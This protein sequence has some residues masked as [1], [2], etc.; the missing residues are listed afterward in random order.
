MSTVRT[1][2]LVLLAACGAA[3]AP[4]V[5][6]TC[7][8]DCNDRDGV[9]I[10]E[11][12]NVVNIFLG[13]MPMATCPNADRNGDGS[14]SIDEVVAAVN[15]FLGDPTSCP[16]VAP[17]TPE[18]T[19]TAT[20]PPDDTATPA[21]TVAPTAPLPSPT[22]TFTT[23][24]TRTLTPPPSATRSPTLTVTST[25]SAT[26]TSTF[27]PTATPAAS[28]TP[29]PAVC[30]NGFLEEGETCAKCAVD[31]KVKSCT[32]TTTVLTFDVTFAPPLGQNASS[33]TALVG[34]RSDTVGLPG[35]GTGSCVGGSKDGKACASGADCPG[36]QCVQPRSRVKNTP[37]GSIVGVND[38]DYAVR[39]VL[40]RSSQIAPGRIFSVDFLGCQGAAAPTAANFGCTVEGCASSFG[41]IDG[42]RCTV[43]AP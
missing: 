7:V 22:T 12:V 25:A 41:S 13:N 28:P 30:G 23:T 31:C 43:V 4:A 39:V 35:K 11:V 42:C 19:E 29:R 6:A 38:L 9:T 24:F 14:L 18:P 37:P 40:T 10:N 36:G 17:D 5:L 33:V 2:I 8:G 26:R 20:V 34:Y 1:S 16:V 3:R 21:P 15:S 32:P 27:T